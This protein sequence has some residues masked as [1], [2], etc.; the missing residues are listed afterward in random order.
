MV[1]SH[2]LKKIMV[3]GEQQML[4]SMEDYLNFA[5]ENSS[6]LIT[7]FTYPENNITDICELIE[8]NEKDADD[9]TMHIKRNITSGAVGAT[10]MENFLSLT[11]I[12][13]DVIDKTYWVARE[14]K[15]TK[16]SLLANSFHEEPLQA[17]YDNFVKILTIN[18]EATEKVRVLLESSS[19]EEVKAAREKI[20]EL[21]ESV[22]EIKDGTIDRLYRISESISFLMFNHVNSIA[23]VL[24]DLLDNYEDISDL[25]LNTMLSVSK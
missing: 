7:I 9:L 1:N 14:M 16:N 13:D 24:D 20:E 4:R 22:D 8:K 18:M 2:F 10:L 5:R 19:V 25:V 17:F 11:E 21:E 3:I 6:S 12:F 23:H 15:R